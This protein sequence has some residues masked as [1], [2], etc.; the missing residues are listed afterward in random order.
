[1]EIES[2]TGFINVNN[3]NNVTDQKILTNT[4]FNII[5]DKYIK[6]LFKN[7]PIAEYMPHQRL[8]NAFIRY[9]MGQSLIFFKF[10]Y[11]PE[12]KIVFDKIDNLLRSRLVDPDMID[13]IRGFYH[14][15]LDKLESAN[16]ITSKQYNNYNQIY[17]IFDTF[18]TTL[19]HN[20]EE[21]I[22]YFN[23]F[24]DRFDH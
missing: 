9:I 10:S 15:Y 11:F 20:V 8:S 1:L 18:I 14:N 24:F 16:L 2:V 4:I 7:I 6:K 3:L 19:S 5:Y 21:N 12:S 23:E 17:P 13:S 22:N